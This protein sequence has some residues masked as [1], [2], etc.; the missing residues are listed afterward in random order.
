[1]ENSD[2]PPPVEREMSVIPSDRE[3]ER[4]RED[5]LATLTVKVCV[6]EVEPHDVQI[7]YSQVC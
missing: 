6:D 2:E 5:K 3:D 7:P 1:M 4:D